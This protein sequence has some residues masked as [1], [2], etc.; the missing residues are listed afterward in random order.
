MSS[1]LANDE[2]YEER[3]IA[4]RPYQDPDL[5]SLGDMVWLTRGVTSWDITDFTTIAIGA[6][7]LFG[8][9]ATGDGAMT[10]IYGGDLILRWTDGSGGRQANLVTWQSEVLYRRF[11][12]DAFVDEQDPA[13]PV[14]V[15]ADTLVD[16]GL[17]TQ[18]DWR[19]DREWAVGMRYEWATSDGDNYDPETRAL[20]PASSDPFRDDR[21]R[22]SPRLTWQATEFSRIRLQY[23]YDRA[24]HLES[25][26][27][28]SVWLGVEV[29]LGPHAAH[30]F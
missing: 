8:P 4:G 3:G 27:A 6:S 7:A 12:A 2:F 20:V 18:L 5:R 9:N 17:Y 14:D 21:T 26:D 11:E 22:L 10:Q 29:S 1:F 28:H 23:N 25:G 13:N 19:F 24:D 16:W 15:P 30:R